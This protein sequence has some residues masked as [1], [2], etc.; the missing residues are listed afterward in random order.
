MVWGYILVCGYDLAFRVRVRFFAFLV[1][2]MFRVGVTLR[3]NV[4]VL[5]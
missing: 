3:V 2:V 5:I 4:R 1:W